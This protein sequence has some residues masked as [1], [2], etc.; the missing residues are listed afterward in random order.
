V[1]QGYFEV[2]LYDFS[3]LSGPGQVI[4]L[5]MFHLPLKIYYTRDIDTNI[6]DNE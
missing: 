1:Q 3:L 2:G 5:L 4:F 6:A